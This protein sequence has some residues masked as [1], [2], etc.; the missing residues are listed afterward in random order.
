MIL[1]QNVVHKKIVCIAL[2]QLY[3]DELNNE[4]LRL[5]SCM[6]SNVPES[7]KESQA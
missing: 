1:T 3:F 5:S 2:N 7:T 4:Q 6:P